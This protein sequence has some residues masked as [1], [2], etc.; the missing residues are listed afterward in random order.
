MQGCG[1]NGTN[2]LGTSG[3]LGTN[4]L[5]TSGMLGANGGVSVQRGHQ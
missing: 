1:V 2:G 5:G 4:G 3:M